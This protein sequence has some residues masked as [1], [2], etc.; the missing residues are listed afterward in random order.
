MHRT[1]QLA[2]SPFVLP[3]AT[4][5]ERVE[6]LREAMRRTFK[7]PEFLKEYKKTGDDSPPLMPEEL[8]RVIKNLPREPE[9]VDLFKN[10]FGAGPLPPR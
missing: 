4:P 3:P 7:D 10:L 9:V 2:G 1:F 5:H 8:E 6:V